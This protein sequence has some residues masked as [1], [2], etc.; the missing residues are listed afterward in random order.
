MD[1]IVKGYM[2]RGRHEGETGV[3]V[4]RYDGLTNT[5]EE[6][7]F[8]ESTECSDV[9]AQ[10]VG[11]LIYISYDDKMYLSFAG[12]IFA[13]DINTKNVEVLTE[14]LNA[15]DYLISRGGDMI[16]WQHGD[17][18]FSSTQIT[19]MDMK[20]GVRQTYTAKD[21]EY[22]RPLGFSNNDFIY[23]VCAETDVAEDFAGNTL[24]PM[25]CVEIVDNKG[26]LIRDF[27][28]LSKNK[29]VIS[30]NMQSNRINLKCVSKNE[31]GNYVETLAEAITSSEEEFVSKIAL[32]ETK[33]DVK[34]TELAFQFE[35]KAEGKMKLI[36]PKQV[37]FE[38]NRN[39][40]LTE[41]DHK[42]FHSYGRGSVTGVHANIRDAVL[43][44][45]QDMGVVTDHNGQVVW[46]RGD[47][48]AR[49]VLTL[50]NETES[51]AASDSLEGALRLLLEQEGVYTDVRSSLD[52]GK[53][54][55]QILQQSSQ[56]QAENFTGCNLSSVLYYISEGEYV[57]AMTAATEAELIVGYDA[58][59][60]YV[61][62]PLTG[63][64]TKMGQKDAAAKYETTG[65]V[66][67]SFL[68]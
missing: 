12:D 58:Q 65:N 39:L 46:N 59:N 55:F 47:R 44:A 51:L 43:A 49:S 13:I 2:N 19:T 37:I 29:Y 34:K 6:L 61:L 40:I 57:L 52:S 24:F 38:E 68:K 5:T 45:Y 42:N 17:D 11:E 18:R 14:D 7:M 53:S 26:S 62:N 10:T 63:K 50:A 56:K 9:L 35:T 41:E 3:A 23:G 22:L 67:F 15:G 36:T 54:A 8:I 16:A 28:Y 48:K 20:T 31:D 66:F 4:M 64:T 1:F 33:H 60:I 32:S 27:D 25:Y 30:A 21:G